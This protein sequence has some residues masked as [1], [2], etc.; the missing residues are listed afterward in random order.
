MLSKEEW[1]KLQGNIRYI[2]FHSKKYDE[3]IMVEFHELLFVL[4]RCYMLYFVKDHSRDFPKKP[5]L[6][7]FLLKIERTFKITKPNQ[8]LIENSEKFIINEMEL[9]NLPQVINEVKEKAPIVKRDFAQLENTGLS[10]SQLIFFFNFL[11]SML[12]KLIYPITLCDGPIQ[13]SDFRSQRSRE[14]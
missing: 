14:K 5:E 2:A 13:K 8:Y 3:K 10:K 9:E 7:D 6:D 1:N 12:F 11:K 4:S